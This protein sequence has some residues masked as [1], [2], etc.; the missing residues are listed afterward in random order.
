[1]Q[2]EET[3]SGFNFGPWML[4]SAVGSYVFIFLPGDVNIIDQHDDPCCLVLVNQLG[5]FTKAEIMLVR[6]VK[7]PVGDSNL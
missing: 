3:G 2:W 6:L 1:M 7:K 4:R 5:F